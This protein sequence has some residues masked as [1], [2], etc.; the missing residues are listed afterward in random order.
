MYSKKNSPQDEN[1]FTWFYSS[2]YETCLKQ[3]N[4]QSFHAKPNVSCFSY[5]I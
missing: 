4:I 5:T 2:Q 3:T 1:M